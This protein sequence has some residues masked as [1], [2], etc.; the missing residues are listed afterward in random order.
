VKTVFAS[1]LFA[2]IT[3]CGQPAQVIL[4]RHAEKPAEADA[5][6]LSPRGEER[7]RALVSLLGGHSLL[8]SNAP[9][10]ALYATRVTKHDRSQRTGE[11]LGPLARD[12]GLPVR[13]PF[14][15]DE[16]SRLAASVLG[17]PTYRG[18]TVIICWT[19]HDLAQFAGA[20]GVRPLPPAWKDNT[21]D[22]LWRITFSPGHTQLIDLPQHLLAGD[23]TH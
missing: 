14:G 16:Y 23:S 21:F 15:S 4:L 12:L 1:I 11:T 2:A 10:V 13:T 19:H 3:A 18:K 9:V 8:T 22:R 7:A 6:H 20:L 17:D 5:V